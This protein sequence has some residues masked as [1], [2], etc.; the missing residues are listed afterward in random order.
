VLL[1]DEHAEDAAA[2]RRARLRRRGGARHACTEIGEG[3]AGYAALEQRTVY[4]Q[5]LQADERWGSVVGAG[6]SAGLRRPTGRCRCSRR[7][8]LQGVIELYAKRAFVPDAEWFEFLETFAD[9][10]AIAVESA[11]LFRSLERSNA[12]CS[13]RTTRPSKA[14]RTRSTSRTRRRRGTASA[15]RR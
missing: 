5:D 15:S 11:L 4:V 7:G 8:S 6:A 1:F 12:S 13:S 10:G 9:Q 3:L 2:H 14:G